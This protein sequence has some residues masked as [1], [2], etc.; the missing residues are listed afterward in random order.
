MW[1]PGMA[2]SE[3][4]SWHQE[5][6]SSLCPEAASTSGHVPDV[7]GGGG[8]DGGGGEGGGGDGLGGDGEDEGGGGLG[9]G[10]G[11]LGEGGGGLGGG[12]LG[13]GGGGEGGGE[14]ETH[15]SCR[16]PSMGS[17]PPHHPPHCTTQRWLPSEQVTL[18]A[19]Y[20]PLD[21]H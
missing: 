8:E 16:M 4:R 20:Q 6:Y 5:M 17:H 3:L 2:N 15:S 12:G 10:S 14:G 21:L 7:T 11:G 19:E 18:T 9:G 1:E 13:E